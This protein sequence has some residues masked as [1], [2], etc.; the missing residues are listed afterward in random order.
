VSYDESKFQIELNVHGFKPE[1]LSIKTEGDVLI[2]H[3]RHESKPESGGN[4]KSNEFEQRFSLP[5]GVKPEL[6]TSKLSE[7]GFLVVTAP[8]EAHQPRPTTT[9]Y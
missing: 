7:S 8:R 4:F 6:I 2:I 3:A 1:D 5:S 9:N